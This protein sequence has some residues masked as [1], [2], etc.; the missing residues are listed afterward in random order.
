MVQLFGLSTLAFCI[1]MLVGSLISGL[2]RHYRRVP[3]PPE[4]GALLRVRAEGSIYRSRFLGV[5]PEGWKF[6]APL[7]RDSFVPLHVGET[8]IVEATDG[9]RVTLFRS[10]LVDRKTEDGTM[11][12]KVP[13]QVFIS[14]KGK[15]RPSIDLGTPDVSPSSALFTQ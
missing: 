9:K 7:Q 15:R 2:I 10:V 14:P 11:T 8:L 1:S 13:K 3:V 6:A 4:I 5:T 12:A